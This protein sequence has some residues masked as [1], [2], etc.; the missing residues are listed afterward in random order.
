MRGRELAPSA[1]CHFDEHGFG[2]WAVEHREVS[3]F[4]G[5]VGIRHVPFDAPF[6]PAI[7]VGCRLARQAWG[8]GY[9]TEAA[10]AVVGHASHELGMSRLVAMTVLGNRRSLAVMERLRMVPV[11]GFEH[12]M[13]PPGHRL[14]PHLLYELR[15]V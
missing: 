3:A 2:L 5:F 14:R 6:G 9:A 1:S 4:I 13:L 15:R 10:H 11:A 7:E 8:L 12:P